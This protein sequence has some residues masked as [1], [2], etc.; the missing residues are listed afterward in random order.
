ML[1]NLAAGVSGK[2]INH[3]EV[4]EIAQRSSADLGVILLRF[5]EGHSLRVVAERL[6]IAEATLREARLPAVFNRLRICLRHRGVEISE[7]FPAQ[8]G[9]VFQ[10]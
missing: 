9:G 2:P 5:F 3:E 8:T 6:G 7:I 10:Y 4:L 1:A